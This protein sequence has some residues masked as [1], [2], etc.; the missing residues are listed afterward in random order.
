[1]V[2]I[3]QLDQK[4]DMKINILLLV[5]HVELIHPRLRESI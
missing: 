4:N 5:N 1:M 2:K 3:T